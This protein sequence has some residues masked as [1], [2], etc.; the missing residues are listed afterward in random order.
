MLYRVTPDGTP[1]TLVEFTGL[2]G[3]KK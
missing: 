2:V 1:T 3:R